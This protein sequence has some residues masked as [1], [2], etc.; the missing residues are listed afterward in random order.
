M[1]RPLTLHL[2]ATLICGLAGVAL[3]LPLLW[4]PLLPAWQGWRPPH[5]SPRAEALL[6]VAMAFWTA[7]CVVDIPRRGLKL[8][9]WVAT[10]WLLGSGIWLCGLFGYASSSLVPV[11]AVALAGAGAL[12]FS[13]T[14]AGSR[15]ARWQSLVGDRVSP[16]FLRA[17]IDERRLE[18]G[19]RTEVLAVVEVLWPGATDDPAKAWDG[20]AGLSKEA[21]RHFQNA[22]GYLERCDAEGARFAFG[23]WGRE[24]TSPGLV[25][26]LWE[27][28]RKAGG[29][30]ALT[31]GECVTG[32]AKFPSGAR[33]TL[34]GSPLRRA[35]RM[36]A[37]ARGY[38]A[39]VIIEDALA[40]DLGDAWLSRRLAWWD[41][42]GDRVL[43]RE[44]TGPSAEA[45]PGSS[46]DLRRWDRAWEAFWSGDWVGAE[47]G[48]A[49]LARERND[50]AARI[51]ALRSAAARR[52]GEES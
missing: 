42:E 22:G 46:D 18:D 24:F 37:A 50:A 15:R 16:E 4:A 21:A 41:F 48:F 51:F 43:L 19:P 31:R 40:D 29:C 35:A 17:R 26:T 44:I 36:A 20:V 28:V 9:V 11:A 38:A 34:A 45:A 39:R 1:N 33:W 49:A 52:H 32:V 3:A 30:G 23:C 12:V 27:W 5:V 47:N 8:L 6:A 14:S 13:F 10:L 25:Q 2:K 7:W